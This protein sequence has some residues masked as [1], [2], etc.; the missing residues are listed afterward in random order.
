MAVSGYIA[1][2]RISVESSRLY[3]CLKKTSEQIFCIFCIRKV[4][5]KRQGVLLFISLNQ[6]L[7]QH[8]PLGYRNHGCFFHA[9]AFDSPARHFPTAWAGTGRP[10]RLSLCCPSMEVPQVSLT[11]P[12]LWGQPGLCLAILSVFLPQLCKALGESFIPS[13]A[14]SCKCVRW[15]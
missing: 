5:S 15:D 12:V 9:Y 13:F 10:C 2:Y 4:A 11:A 7:K 1:N 14:S 3:W 8:S 6:V